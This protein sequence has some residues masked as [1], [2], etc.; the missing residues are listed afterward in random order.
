MDVLKNKAFDKIFNE[1]YKIKDNYGVNKQVEFYDTITNVIKNGFKS[2]SGPINM[3]AQKA[4]WS[5]KTNLAVYKEGLGII[6][7]DSLS[8]LE[9]SEGK[10]IPLENFNADFFEYYFIMTKTNP[11]NPLNGKIGQDKFRLVERSNK[12]VLEIDIKESEAND[13]PEIEKLEKEK[14][15][16]EDKIK[17]DEDIEKKMVDLSKIPGLT[18]PEKCSDM[19]SECKMDIQK[20]ENDKTELENK[21]KDSDDSVIDEKIK[22]INSS[23]ESYKSM[24]KDID[25][26]KKRQEEAKIEIINKTRKDQLEVEIAK[27]KKDSKERAESKGFNIQDKEIDGKKYISF[28][29]KEYL[30]RMIPAFQ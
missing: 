4:E 25:D 19:Q 7:I 13:N 14:K 11:N 15:I 23:I 17:L 12:Y 1:L 2:K 9:T 5:K 24:M 10:R 6:P 26:I 30:E 3:E 18:S 8:N 16:I 21:K 22:E 28:S 27:L 29:V 20:M